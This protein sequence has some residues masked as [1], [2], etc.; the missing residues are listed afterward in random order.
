M[1]ELTLTIHNGTKNIKTVAKHNDRTANGSKN[2]KSNLNFYWDYTQKNFT[3]KERN[4]TDL[5]LAFYEKHFS[6]HVEEQNEK[7][8]K[9][10]HE[11]RNKTIKGLYTDDRTKPKE[12]IFELGNINESVDKKTFVKVLCEYLNELKR[13]YPNIQV[14]DVAIHFDEATPHA[15]IRTVNIAHDKQGNEFISQTKALKEMNIPLP[16][17]QKKESKFNNR[18]MTLTENLRNHIIE[19]CHTIGIEIVSSERGELSQTRLTKEQYI[20]QK[21][22]EKMKE[23]LSKTTQQL[24][25]KKEQI[26]EITFQ[27]DEE[28]EYKLELEDYNKEIEQYNNELLDNSKAILSQ[29]ITYFTQLQQEIINLQTIDNIQEFKIKKREIQQKQQDLNSL[30]EEY[31]ADYRKEFENLTEEQLQ[32]TI[33]FDDYERL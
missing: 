14:L 8:K 10:R 24:E 15:H 19:F 30:L 21:E 26:E 25:R 3:Q 16:N 23:E 22:L 5:E 4:F 2:E 9:N 11:E 12:T 20:Q 27:I 29:F 28:E 17:P 1:K 6:K 13:N 33:G 32:D 7:N 18:T 31:K